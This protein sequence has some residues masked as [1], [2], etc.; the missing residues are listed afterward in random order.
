LS[1]E[2][3]RVVICVF[4]GQITGLHLSVWSIRIDFMDVIAN[5]KANR[6]KKAQIAV[7]VT[8]LHQPLIYRMIEAAKQQVAR[9]KARVVRVVNVPESYKLADVAEAALNRGDVDGVLVL[10]FIGRSEVLRDDELLAKLSPTAIALL[11]ATATAPID[12]AQASISTYDSSKIWVNVMGEHTFE[13]NKWAAALTELSEYGLVE[14]ERRLTQ[15]ASHA[16]G[17]LGVVN[18]RVTERGHRLVT[19]P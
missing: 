18:F 3:P 4:F 9:Q 12:A 8:A 15:P 19:K 7:V 13:G 1:F 10:G 14:S 5:K 17:R 6:Y 16:H 2:R 11:E